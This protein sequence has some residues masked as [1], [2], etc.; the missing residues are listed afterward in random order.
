M[1]RERDEMEVEGMRWE[2]LLLHGGGGGVK[3]DRISHCIEQQLTRQGRDDGALWRH[4]RASQ[5]SEGS[6]PGDGMREGGGGG[7]EMV[8]VVMMMV[9]VEKRGGEA[10]KGAREE[11]KVKEEKHAWKI[12]EKWRRGGGR[13]G[14][15]G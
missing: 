9:V 14:K 15:D 5:L 2:D 8:I 6:W 1:W 10:R 13:G 12:L 11:W 3:A 7:A 4:P